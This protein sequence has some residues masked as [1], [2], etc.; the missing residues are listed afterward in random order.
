M[1]DIGQELTLRLCAH[2]T[3]DVG[4]LC[5]MVV[6]LLGYGDREWF[7]VRS[8]ETEICRGGTPVY[9][10]MVDVANDDRADGYETHCSAAGDARE[11]VA[12]LRAIILTLRSLRRGSES[13]KESEKCS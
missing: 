1:T 5:R 4:A 12:A 10:L 2:E 6:D 7:I 8:I 13:S 11:F 9:A 3:I